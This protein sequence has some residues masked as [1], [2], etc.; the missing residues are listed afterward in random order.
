MLSCMQDD[1]NFITDWWI[2]AYRPDL[3]ANAAVHKKEEEELINAKKSS[4]TY[5]D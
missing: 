5:V 1:Q 3:S 4:A 2:G